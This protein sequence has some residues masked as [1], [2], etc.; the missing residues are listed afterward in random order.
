MQGNCNTKLKRHQI[1]KLICSLISS[2]PIDIAWTS[3]PNSLNTH[4][5]ATRSSALNSQTVGK[6]FSPN[7]ESCS[8]LTN[9]RQP[10]LPSINP[11]VTRG[12]S[13]LYPC[14][15]S[16]C[17]TAWYHWRSSSCIQMDHWFMLGHWSI[18]LSPQHNLTRHKTAVKPVP[19]V[20][21]LQAAV[22]AV[23][24]ATRDVSGL[25]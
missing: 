13:V 25:L 15:S 23:G 2:I 24:W 21:P 18:F 11:P 20:V 17:R 1:R 4:Y 22:A 19:C 3:K 5:L 10:Q 7:L 12:E 6:L 14:S 8:S 9:S 16:P